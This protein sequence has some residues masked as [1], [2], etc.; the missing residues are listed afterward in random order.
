MLDADLQHPY[1]QIK[2]RTPQERRKERDVRGQAR[3]MADMKGQDGVQ[4]DGNVIRAGAELLDPLR[5]N[6]GANG[7]TPVVVTGCLNGVE[8]SAVGAYFTPP[9]PL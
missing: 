4:V 9:S 2:S 1:H 5:G 6:G 3:L 8:S 7:L